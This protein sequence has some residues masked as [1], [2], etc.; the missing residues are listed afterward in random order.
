MFILSVVRYNPLQYKAVEFYPPF[1][2]SEIYVE[3]VVD[4][5]LEDKGSLSDRRGEDDWLKIDQELCRT[6]PAV[7]LR[8]AG[9][10]CH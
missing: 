7:R 8:S 6:I 5:R 9:K 4:K 2:L 1:Q 10:K 3:K